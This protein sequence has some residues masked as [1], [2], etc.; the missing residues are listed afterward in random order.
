MI[1]ARQQHEGSGV[2]EGHGTLPKAKKPQNHQ[3]SPASEEEAN[4][5]GTPE[6]K[7]NPM[8][9]QPEKLDLR[10]RDIAEDN[11]NADRDGSHQLGDRVVHG[12]PHRYDQFH[13]DSF[14]DAAR[15][16]EIGTFNKYSL[17]ITP[18]ANSPGSV[19]RG[20]DVIRSLLKINPKTG[21]PR[22]RIHKR[23]RHLIEEM[24]KYRW[25]RRQSHS[26]DGMVA[27]PRPEPLKKDDDTICSTRYML[28]G[29]TVNEGLGI[30]STTSRPSEKRADV[31][32]HLLTRRQ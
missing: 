25:I 31:Q 5:E 26:V 15:P 32:I 7:V 11:R 30:G 18:A 22:L 23:C 3:S 29:A 6:M 16:G 17:L 10:S 4:Q 2:R 1:A 27:A 28:V 12:N 21:M 9:D 13:G 24:R 20:I 14:A 8:T 19:I